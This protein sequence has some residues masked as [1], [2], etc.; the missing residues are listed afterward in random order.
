MTSAG[1]HRHNYGQGNSY[2][3]KSDT[4]HSGHPTCITSPKKPSKG[5]PA[6]SGDCTTPHRQA[7]CYRSAVRRRLLTIAIFLLAGAVVNV[8]VAWGI[9]LRDPWGLRPPLQEISVGGLGALRR[10]VYISPLAVGYVPERVSVF[11]VTPRLLGTVTA[12]DSYYVGDEHLFGLPT[13]ALVYDEWTDAR[14]RLRPYGF[15]VLDNYF[16]YCPIWPG[17]ARV[18]L[19]PILLLRLGLTFSL[20]RAF[21]AL[22]LRRREASR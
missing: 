11:G 5:S 17:F 7:Q 6:V 14:T 3:R 19:V 15:W 20:Q 16:P 1:V 18:E 10:Y 12:L 21:N 2:V 8:A 9:V 22:D 4:A 13:R